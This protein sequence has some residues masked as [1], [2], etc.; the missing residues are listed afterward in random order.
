MSPG[1][2]LRLGRCIGVYLSGR[3]WLLSG[4]D[5][6]P[7]LVFPGWILASIEYKHMSRGHDPFSKSV[8]LLEPKNNPQS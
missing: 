5:A 8:Y 3:G 7:G 1:R 2:L 6:G 4:L